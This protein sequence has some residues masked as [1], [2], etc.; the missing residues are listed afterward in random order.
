MNN[1]RLLIVDDESSLRKVLSDLL[2][3]K[4]YSPHAVA[5]GRAAIE[6][7]KAED[8]PGVAI[9][10]LSLK[11]MSGLDVI[12][13]I[14][15][16]A[17]STE[18]IVLT[19]KPSSESKAA[20]EELGAH[21]YIVKPFNVNELL[22][23]IREAMEKHAG[24]RDGEDASEGKEPSEAGKKNLAAKVEQLRRIADTIAT[25]ESLEEAK[26]SAGDLLSETEGLAEL[27]D[28]DTDD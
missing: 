8:P 19:G 28:L 7:I 18:C 2:R 16:A 14:R 23:S 22:T 25:T 3:T 17:P 1:D 6:E 5:T 10:D 9:V 27:T 15:E 12:G 4:G 20:A 13:Q 21:A 26:K 11:H 24:Q